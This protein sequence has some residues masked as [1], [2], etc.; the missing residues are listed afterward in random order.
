MINSIKHFEEKSIPVFEKLEGDFYRNPTDVASFVTGLTEELHQVGL[1]MVKEVLENMNLMLKE[2]GKRVQSWVV[3]KDVEKQLLTSLGIVRYTK[4][5]FA[6]KETGEMEFLLDRIMGLE[7]HAR[8]TEDAE[9]RLLMEAVQSSY[10]R[11]GESASIL[12][13]V[14]KQTVKNKIHHLKFPKAKIPVQKKVADYLYIDADEDHVAL[15]FREKK[16]DIT[17]TED[18]HKNNCQISKLV[19][20]Y[21]G[22]EPESPKSKRN[23]LVEPYYFSRVCEGK[24]NEEL[25]D[26]IWEYINNTYDLAKVKKIYLNA[27]GGTW[28]EAGRKRLSGVTGVLDEFHLQKYMLKLTSNPKLLDSDWDARH[29]LYTALKRGTK[30]EFMYW[31]KKVDEYE[32]TEAGHKRIRESAEY[33]LSNWSAARTRVQKQDGVCGCS[34]EG[35]VSHVLS[36]RMSS[37]PMGWSKTG[38]AKMSELRAYYYNKKDMLELVRYQ[39]EKLPKAAGMEYPEISVTQILRSEQKQHTMLGKYLESISHSV[40][41]STKKKAWF[42]SHIWGL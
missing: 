23:K 31:I 29:R 22:V 32:E 12:D 5:L 8:M 26:E 21:E 13:S 27:D 37:R 17:V 2:S 41:L 9:A 40:S 3:E 36:A 25:W 30:E 15:Q 6:N 39:K 4:T 7:K 18:G 19:Y 34:A 10:R 35:H 33:I 16:G 11:G 38:V 28:I 42:Q 14:S 24:G 20:V 1:L